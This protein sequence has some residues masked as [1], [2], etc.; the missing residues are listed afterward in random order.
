MRNPYVIIKRMTVDSTLNDHYEI[1]WKDIFKKLELRP[2][3]YGNCWARAGIL[4]QVTRLF[5]TL[6]GERV[7]GLICAPKV[8][9][10]YRTLSL[11]P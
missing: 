10:S 1:N 2:C 3:R 7:E 9:I 6:L 4:Q 11:M 8:I 5:N